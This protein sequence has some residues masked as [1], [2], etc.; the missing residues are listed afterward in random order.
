MTI[1]GAILDICLG[2][3]VQ[4]AIQAVKMYW[5]GARTSIVTDPEACDWWKDAAGDSN[6][7]GEI[8]AIGPLSISSRMSSDTRE[9]YASDNVRDWV[10]PRSVDVELKGHCTCG[11]QTTARHVET[12]EDTSA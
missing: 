10:Y 8:I 9:T 3:D 4:D 6:S 1:W 11:G 12:Y 2:G 5:N 7:S